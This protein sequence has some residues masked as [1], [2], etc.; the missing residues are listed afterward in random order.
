MASTLGEKT[1]FK[2]MSFLSSAFDRSKVDES[3]DILEYP[4]KIGHLCKFI[5]NDFTQ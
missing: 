4:R 1:F 5:H 3:L 2:K